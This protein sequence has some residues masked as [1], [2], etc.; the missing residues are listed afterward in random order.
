M[1]GNFLSGIAF[2]T[3]P[4]LILART[5][6]NELVFGTIQSVAGI[7]G[8]LGALLMSAWG[9]PKRRV[10][11]VLIGWFLSGLFGMTLMG[12][13]QGIVLWVVGG[14]ISVF[15]IPIINGSNQAIWQAKVAPDLQGR[16]FSVRRVIAWVTTPLAS[17]IAIPLAD[18]LLGP[19]MEEGGSLVPLFGPLVGS[20]AGAGISVIWVAT[21][22]LTAVVAL[23]AY[24][25]PVIRNAEELL[26][27][28]EAA[29]GELA[30]PEAAMVAEAELPQGAM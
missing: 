21:G 10:H 2:V 9:G 7:G 22:L 19:A 24:L 1:I 29:G 30:R 16:V 25:F 11:G 12:L 3:L 14:F 27:D 28:H 8:V 13:A 18:S 6:S 15:L 4:A 20:G 26:P 5:N 17:V 23:V